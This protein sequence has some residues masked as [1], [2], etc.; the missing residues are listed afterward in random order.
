MG[1]HLCGLRSCDKVGGIKEVGRVVEEGGVEGLR[2]MDLDL[3][4][5]TRKRGRERTSIKRYVFHNIA[6]FIH[7][8]S[9][10]KLRA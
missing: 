8:L 1:S 10:D 3:K 7:I 6:Y 2:D 5:V 4:A 9:K